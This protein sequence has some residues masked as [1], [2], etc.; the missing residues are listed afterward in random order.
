MEMVAG[1]VVG[2]HGGDEAVG[3]ASL[4]HTFAQTI[5]ET[6]EMLG[7]LLFLY[8]ELDYLRRTAGSVYIRFGSSPGS[9]E[10]KD[11]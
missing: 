4:S 3:T 2:A 6:L 5:E 11:A 1:A 7:V 9:A 10:V 8:A